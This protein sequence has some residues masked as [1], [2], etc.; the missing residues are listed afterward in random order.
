MLPLTV[1]GSAL[2]A[3][4][5]GAYASASVAHAA[6]DGSELGD[7]D[8]DSGHLQLRLGYAFNRYLAIEAEGSLAVLKPELH[9]P[10]EGSRLILD[11][12]AAAF[13]VARLP[14]GDRVTLH[15]RG[16]YYIGTVPLEAKGARE[17]ENFDD[18]AYGLGL[19]YHWDRN[20]IR[21]DYTALTGSLDDDQGPKLDHRLIGIAFVRSF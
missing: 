6:T 20:A 18:F 21:A 7:F 3:Q 1:P 4:D 5:A 15:A 16:G 19:S 13:A 10:S 9:D 17:T 12:Y 14:V 11:R 8:G 2:R